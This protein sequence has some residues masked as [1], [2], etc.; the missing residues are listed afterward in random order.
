MVA[1]TLETLTMA[2]PAVYRIRV[3]GRI[4]AEWAERIEGMNIT[5]SGGQDHTTV[6]VGRLRDQSMLS[7]VLQTLYELHMPVLSVDCLE[8]G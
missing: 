5:E 6:L 7:G 8:K 2:D 1:H 3:R 4:D